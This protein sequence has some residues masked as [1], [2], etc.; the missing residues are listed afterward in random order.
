MVERKAGNE[1]SHSGW[2]TKTASLA[3]A[4]ENERLQV[5][6]SAWAHRAMKVEGKCEELQ[7][8]KSLQLYD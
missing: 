5:E 3:L 7:K 8:V 2:S 6:L 4:A 1:V